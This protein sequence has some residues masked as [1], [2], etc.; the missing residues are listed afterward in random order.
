MKTSDNL[1]NIGQLKKGWSISG[2]VV[3]RSRQISQFWKN[4]PML[5]KL[6]IVEKVET[7]LI[8]VDDFWKVSQFWKNGQFGNDRSI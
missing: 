8:K 3:V 5:K 7:I 4:L 1:R 6:F 2:R